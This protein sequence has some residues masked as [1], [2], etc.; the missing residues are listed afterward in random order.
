M[1]LV[2]SFNSFSKVFYPIHTQ[3]LF[4]GITTVQKP[5]RVLARKGSKIVSGLTSGERGTLV[6]LGFAV[7][8]FGNSIPPIFLFPRKKFFVSRH[9]FMFFLENNISY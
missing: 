2:K 1:K 3:I 6:T 8:A 5:N 7:S 4:E 9:K